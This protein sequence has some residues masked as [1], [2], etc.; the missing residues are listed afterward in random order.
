MKNKGILIILS[1]LFVA[2]NSPKKEE[3]AAA[4]T[5]STSTEAP[6]SQEVNK[7]QL[8]GKWLQPIPG[9]ENQKQ[10]FQLNKDN[11]ASSLNIHTL[12]YDKWEVSNDKLLLWSHTEGVKEASANVDTLLIKKLTETELVVSPLKGGPADEQTYNKEK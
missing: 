12:L 11:T 9:Q 2:C 1:A 7:D 4:D 5:T 3:A 6:A 8:V 10:G